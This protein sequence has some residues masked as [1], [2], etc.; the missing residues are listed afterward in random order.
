[1][2]SNP[3]TPY[4]R[5][6][7]A[8]LGAL[9][10]AFQGYLSDGGLVGAEIMQAFL[11]GLGAFMLYVLPDAPGFKYVKPIVLAVSAALQLLVAANEAGEPYDDRLWLNVAISVLTLLGVIVVQNE[12]EP[13]VPPTAN[14]VSTGL[15]RAA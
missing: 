7:M 13:A 3:L 5:A 15:P 10:V 9:L 11:A 1:M 4:R 12:P 14:T 6:I 8:F 2:G